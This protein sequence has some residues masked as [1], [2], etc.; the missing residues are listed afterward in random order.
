MINMRAALKAVHTLGRVIA[1]TGECIER[2]VNR[3][4]VWLGYDDG[5]C[6]AWLLGPDWPDDARLTTRPQAGS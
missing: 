5:K 4:A 1:G 6:R 2:G 3:L